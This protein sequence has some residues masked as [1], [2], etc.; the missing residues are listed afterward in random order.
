M[1]ADLFDEF[2]RDMARAGSRRAFV[3]RAL[4]L[5]IGGVIARWSIGSARAAAATNLPEGRTALPCQSHADCPCGYCA[6]TDDPNAPGLCVSGCQPCQRCVFATNR[7]VDNCPSACETCR[8]G[9]CQSDCQGPCEVCENGRCRA[10]GGPCETCLSGVCERCDPYCE[11]CL[12]GSGKCASNC[13]GHKTCCLGQCVDCCGLCDRQHG[14][15]V[16]FQ[17]PDQSFCSSFYEEPA[18]CRGLCVDL[19]WNRENCG[20]CG[21][22][23]TGNEQCTHGRCVPHCAKSGS[24]ERPSECCDGYCVAPSLYQEDARNCGRCGNPCKPNERCVEGR[25]ICPYRVCGD[26][27]CAEYEVCLNGTCCE[28]CGKTCCRPQKGVA[29]RCCNGKCQPADQT[30]C[31]PGQVEGCR[32]DHCCPK[33]QECCYGALTG[34]VKIGRACCDES[35]ERYCPASDTCCPMHLDCCLNAEGTSTCGRPCPS[36][37]Q[38]GA[39]EPA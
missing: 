22:P 5:T 25:C 29:Q 34:C 12:P 10:C 21:H 2:A 9:I 39:S 31:P 26:A 11:V 16:G 6:A 17:H 38:R 3:V 1:S 18:C 4:V 30:C 13:E 28:P 36:G 14:I 24:C 23:C 8:Q 35:R 15:C 20:E 33:D 32:K 27:C 19:Q 7:C 37:Y